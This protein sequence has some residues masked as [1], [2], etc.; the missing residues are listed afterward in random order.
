MSLILLVVMSLNY[1]MAYVSVNHGYI[2]F[3]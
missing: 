2:Q 3:Y 1:K